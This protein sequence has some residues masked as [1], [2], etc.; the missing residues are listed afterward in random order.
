MSKKQCETCELIEKLKNREGVETRYV[1]AYERK[2]I[3][4]EGPV[5]VIIVKD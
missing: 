2:N 3:K 1:N 5:V 4:V